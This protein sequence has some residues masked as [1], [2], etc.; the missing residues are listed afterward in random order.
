MMKL[1]EELTTSKKWLRLCSMSRITG[2]WNLKEVQHFII[3]F[4]RAIFFS[5]FV[6]QAKG[7]V[8]IGAVTR[9]G[10]LIS[11]DDKAEGVTKKKSQDDSDEYS[12]G[13]FASFL[14]VLQLSWSTWMDERGWGG[15]VTLNSTGGS[16][17]KWYFFLLMGFIPFNTVLQPFPISRRSSSLGRKGR[18]LI[19]SC[20]GGISKGCCAGIG[21]SGASIIFTGFWKSI[22]FIQRMCQLFH[23]YHFNLFF[24]ASFPRFLWSMKK[25]V[26]HTLI[27][28][29][30]LSYIQWVLSTEN[31][32]AK[33]LFIFSFGVAYPDP[34]SDFTRL[35]NSNL[36]DFMARKRVFPS[37]G[38]LD[39]GTYYI[40]EVYC[41][42]LL[43]GE[44]G[45][46]TYKAVL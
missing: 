36:E 32:K 40:P 30:S 23:V 33:I 16:V 6:V 3:F 12:G 42:R 31:Q 45:F 35:T 25:K 11:L 14:K 28:L 26:K 18:S 29:F 24:A 46:S 17:D 43:L 4:E 44:L 38:S 39:T 13:F 37:L 21:C 27:I 19:I 41:C 9:M 15:G 2:T 10:D 7:V 22:G 8:F 20:G 1:I 5:L 34:F